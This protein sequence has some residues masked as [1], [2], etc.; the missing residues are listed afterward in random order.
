MKIKYKIQII[1]EYISDDGNKRSIYFYGDDENFKINKNIPI[2]KYEDENFYISGQ[3]ALI[4]DKEYFNK[5]KIIELEKY[6]QDSEN[7]FIFYLLENLTHFPELKEG[8]ILIGRFDQTAVGGD[9]GADDE[10]YYAILRKLHLGDKE[11]MLDGYYDKIIKRPFDVS[12]IILQENFKFVGLPKKTLFTHDENGIFLSDILYKGFFHD[13]RKHGLGEA[14]EESRIYY[15]D[16]LIY[17]NSQ[18]ISENIISL[19]RARYLIS[20]EGSAIDGLNK[21]FWKDKDL[22]IMAAKNG[23]PYALR[24]C[25]SKFRN[26]IDIVKAA[27]D[28]YFEFDDIRDDYRD[29]CAELIGKKLMHDRDFIKESIE[30]NHSF[31]YFNKHAKWVFKDK[32]LMLLEIRNGLGWCFHKNMEDSLPFTID[33]FLLKDLDIIQAI[34]KKSK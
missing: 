4:W 26:D 18:V 19:D 28:F 20:W 5:S 23:H 6:D 32:E 1:D 11:R 34:E 16:E 30:Y 27:T 3:G 12:N 10:D 22:V 7:Y 21:K 9:F 31:I 24:I 8:G 29:E 13:G 14:Q 17:K 33:K 15:E 25:G 2:P